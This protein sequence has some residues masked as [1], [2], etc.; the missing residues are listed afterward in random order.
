MAFEVKRF[1][2]T[3]SVVQSDEGFAIFLDKRGLKTP[4]KNTLSVPTKTYAEAIAAEWQLVEGKVNKHLMPMTRLAEAAI[5]GAK[6][7]YKEIVDTLTGYGGTDMLCYRAESPTELAVRQA[8]NWDPLLAW[9]AQELQ[10]P[11]VKTSGIIAVPQPDQSLKTLR[12]NIE[13]FDL[14]QLTA[15]YDLV[16]ISGSLILALAVVRGHVS[17]TQ[18]WTLSRVDED[19]QIEQWGTDDEAQALAESKL[20]DFCHAARIF[21]LLIEF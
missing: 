3:A 17:A 16:K 9:A 8:Q 14:F 10:A 20:A 7:E 2:E 19:W 15:F 4:L 21:D 18:A 11:L 5:D 1:W 6:I 12:K 13:A